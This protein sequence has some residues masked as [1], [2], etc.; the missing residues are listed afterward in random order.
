MDW[1]RLRIF[2]V[3]AQAGSLTEA[4]Y[5]L[6]VSQSAVSRQISS[7]EK[8]L[9]TTLFVRHPRGLA[10]TE[11]GEHLF[12][13]TQEIFSQVNAISTVIRE[14]KDSISGSLKIATTVGIGSVWLAS[15]LG[16]FIEQYPDIHL[17]VKLTDEEV[18][19][20]LREVDVI[21]NYHQLQN[22]DQ[23]IVQEA[24]STIN[25]GVYASKKY[26]EAH[27]TPKK[28]EDLD[29]HRIIAFGSQ[30]APA[31]NANW[32]LR[33]GLKAGSIRSPFLSINNAYG[34]LQAAKQN[35]G[36]AFLADFIAR[37]HEELV[38]LFEAIPTPKMQMYLTYPKALE[39]IG[40]LGAFRNFL[41]TQLK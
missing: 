7:L 2:H 12:K 36:I 34:M 38:Q 13:T 5:R 31:D 10:L 20:S 21:L 4:G 8:E 27:G 11:T 17:D 37:D 14:T 15:R 26:L 16:D 29:K 6:N 40:R 35:V 41:I 32:L 1:D 18:N 22:H 9:S 25:M 33:L 39:S 19:F 30:G 23:D 28:P 24:L 3:V